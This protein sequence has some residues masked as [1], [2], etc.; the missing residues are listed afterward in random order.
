MKSDN[1]E[2]EEKWR[3]FLKEGHNIIKRVDRLVKATWEPK[4]LFEHREATQSISEAVNAL[5][6][7]WIELRHVTP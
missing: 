2:R 4:P 5:E 1:S 7:W 6:E 3:G